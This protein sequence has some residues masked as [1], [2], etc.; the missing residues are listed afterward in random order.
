M[1]A[2]GWLL[3]VPG[4]SNTVLEMTVP[5]ARDSLVSILGKVCLACCPLTHS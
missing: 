3:S 5:Y 1:Q 4:A 2:L